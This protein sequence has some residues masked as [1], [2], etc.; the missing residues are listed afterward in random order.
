[1][2]LWG[3][4]GTHRQDQDCSSEGLLSGETFD[5]DILSDSFS[6]LKALNDCNHRDI[7]K[8]VNHYNYYYS[9]TYYNIYH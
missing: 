4:A 1:M 3:D 9:N 6:A 2:M 8:T 5:I 7:K